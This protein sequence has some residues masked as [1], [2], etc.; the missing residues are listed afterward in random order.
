VTCRA[1]RLS[2][3]FSRLNLV[4]SCKCNS[5]D[6][7][8]CCTSKPRDRT[9][10]QRTSSP[11]SRVEGG[12]TAQRR[13]PM[14]GAACRLNRRRC[15]QVNLTYERQRTQKEDLWSVNVAGDCSSVKFSTT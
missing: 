10:A 2:Q 15:T 4:F 3:D 14:R 9:C 7:E 12:R 6:L 13:S 1:A 5:A 8:V 11:R